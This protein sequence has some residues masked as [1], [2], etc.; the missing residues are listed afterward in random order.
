MPDDL[1]APGAMTALPDHPALMDVPSELDGLR[2]VVQGL[3]L[4]RD[5]APAYGV[6]GD[7]IRIDEQNLRSTADVL[8]RALEISN[9]RITVTRPPVDRVLCICRHF[10]LLHTALLRSQGVPSRVRTRTTSR[11]GSS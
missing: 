10:M 9:E 11:L 4:H 6:L 7:A 8:T 2:G 1:S 5:W 3:L